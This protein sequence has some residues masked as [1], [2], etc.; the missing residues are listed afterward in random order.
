MAT[1]TKHPDHRE[2]AEAATGN[3]RRPDASMSLLTDVVATSLDP[4]YRAAHASGAAPRARGLLLVTLL[5]AGVLIGLAVVQ[6][7][8]QQPQAAK[9]RAALIKQVQDQQQAQAE[10]RRNLAGV[11]AEVDALQVEAIGKDSSTNAMLGMLGATS[12]AVAVT[13]PGIVITTDDS[14]RLSGSQAQVLDQ[15]LR[16]LVNGLWSAGAEAIAI[17]G[18]RLSSRTA[19]RGAGSAITVDY[20]SLTRPYI[21]EAIGDP[22]TLPAQWARSSGATWWDYLKQNYGM[23]YEVASR[24]ALNLPADPGLGVQKAGPQR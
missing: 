22:N 24:A 4:G 17:N 16:Q 7:S 8:A 1:E 15:D 5:I 2:G 18:H 14:T 20:T 11:Q 3:G 10:L 12:G 13:G 19:I 9:E 6:N 23:R 21:V